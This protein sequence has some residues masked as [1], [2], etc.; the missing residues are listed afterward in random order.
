MFI[1]FIYLRIQFHE[2]ITI[3]D[4]FTFELT[5]EFLIFDVKIINT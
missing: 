1:L 3:F 4:H 2:V 5:I